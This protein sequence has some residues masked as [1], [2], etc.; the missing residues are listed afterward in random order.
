MLHFLLSSNYMSLPSH[1]LAAHHFLPAL[2]PILST[3]LMQELTIILQYK[4]AF[5]FI[6]VF[7]V[8]GWFSNTIEKKINTKECLQDP[9]HEIEKLMRKKQ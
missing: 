8:L 2:I 6:M 7:I 1:G 9:T 5:F 4:W 3:S